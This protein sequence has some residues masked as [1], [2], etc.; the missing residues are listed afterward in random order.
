MFDTD[1]RPVRPS[2]LFLLEEWRKQFKE[3]LLTLPNGYEGPGIETE[4]A[5]RNGRIT[6]SLTAT[7]IVCL[8]PYIRNPEA[9]HL[10]AVTGLFM[11]CRHLESNARRA[12]MR[13]SCIAVPNA[14]ADYQKIV[15]RVGFVETA[16]DCKVYRRILA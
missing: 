3:G 12:G 5:L 6:G 15:E 8:D 10:E 4:V 11:L 7:T 13:E 2:D 1:H 16:P 14:L 9:N